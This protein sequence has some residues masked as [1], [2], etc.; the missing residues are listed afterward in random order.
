MSKEKDGDKERGPKGG[1]KHQPGRGHKRKSG[2]SA[3]RRFQKRARKKKSEELAEVRRMW[4]LWDGLSEE[5][6][7]FRQ[8]LKPKM[9]RPKDEN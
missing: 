1:I 3:K 5:Q 2:P 8:E 7:K 4:Q 9:P 6:K